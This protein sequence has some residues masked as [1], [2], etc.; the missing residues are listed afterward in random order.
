MII[1]HKIIKQMVTEKLY[2]FREEVQGMWW[3][4]Y[5]ERYIKSGEEIS[6]YYINVE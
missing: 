3:E 1:I 5:D 6:L 4:N 2:G